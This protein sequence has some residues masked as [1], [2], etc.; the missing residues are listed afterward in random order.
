MVSSATLVA[1]MSL[2]FIQVFWKKAVDRGVKLK[3]NIA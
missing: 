1:Q 2:L 3:V